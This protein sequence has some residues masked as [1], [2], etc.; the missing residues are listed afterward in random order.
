MEI[1]QQLREQWASMHEEASDQDIKAVMMLLETRWWKA[2]N[3]IFGD[4]DAG[5]PPSPSA[6]AHEHYARG[7]SLMRADDSFGASEEFW[8]ADDLGHPGAPRQL[9]GLAGFRGVDPS[10]GACQELL[11][12]ARD[13]GDGHAAGLIGYF[14]HDAQGLHALRVADESGDAEGARNHGLRLQE[15]GRMDE[16]HAA[17][18]RSDERGSASGT[19]ALANFL[20]HKRDDRDAAEVAYRRAEARGHPRASTNLIDI[21]RERG[22][23]EA[24]ERSAEL[25][26]SNAKK[27]ASVF[28]DIDKPEVA[29][30]LRRR[31]RTPVGPTAASSG[32]CAMTLVAPLAVWAVACLA[33]VRGVRACKLNR[34]PD[35]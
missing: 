6:E 14:R 22:D 17:F 3:A 13:R 5:M 24:A 9:F 15:L 10:C 19:L 32:G 2:M 7:I 29:E 18:R 4:P 16:A 28:A 23:T 35:R 30:M 34:K 20:F 33:H 26:I 1:S 12:R 27:H 31:A 11:T 8:R 21:Y 25:A